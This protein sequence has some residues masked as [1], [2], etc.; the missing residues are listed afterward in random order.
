MSCI[1]NLSLHG[2]LRP[3]FAEVSII[4][5]ILGIMDKTSNPQLLVAAATALAGLLCE[6]NAL[7]TMVNKEGIKI[8]IKLIQN[9]EFP[10]VAS[11]VPIIH[12]A[13]TYEDIAFEMVEQGVLEE[14]WRRQDLISVNGPFRTAFERLLCSNLSAKFSIAGHLDPFEKLP[15]AFYDYGAVKNA[16][17][18]I[19]VSKMVTKPSGNGDTENLKKILYLNLTKTVRKELIESNPI[20]AEMINKGNTIQNIFEEILVIIETEGTSS[21]IEL[22]KVIARVVSNRFGGPVDKLK[23]SYESEELELANLQQQFQSIVVPI[24]MLSAGSHRPRAILFKAL[25]DAFGIPCS[26]DRGGYRKVWNVVLIRSQKC[27]KPC[28]CTK[29]SETSRTC[30][31]EKKQANAVFT[32]KLQKYV[33]DL[34]HHPGTLLPFHSYEANA[35]CF[36]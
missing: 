7:E 30:D 25:A 28:S 1:H 5:G 27:D 18:I 26:L 17:D 3:Y 19:T 32:E 9:D 29:S 6:Y 10:V 13:G 33:V 16:E 36:F 8:L 20:F 21:E 31:T 15:D 12:V 11:V 24:T 2:A 4:A 34:V 23:V 14:L 22:L 35:Y